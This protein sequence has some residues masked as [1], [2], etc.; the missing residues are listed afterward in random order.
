MKSF[1]KYLFIIIFLLGISTLMSQTESEDTEFK[2]GETPIS[3][4]ELVYTPEPIPEYIQIGA[5]IALLAFF[6]ILVFVW[7]NTHFLFGYFLDWVKIF[8]PRMI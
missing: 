8:V 2:F 1:G 5:P 6:F 4:S 7:Y 3:E